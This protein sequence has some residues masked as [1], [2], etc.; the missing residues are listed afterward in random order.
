[1]AGRRDREEIS[2][3]NHPPFK[4]REENRT[5][6]RNW[7]LAVLTAV[8]T[9]HL[10][11]RHVVSLLLQPI[12]DDLRLTD[13]QLGVITGIAFGLF[14]ATLGVPIARWADRGNRVTII[15]LAIA[16]WSVTV[17][18][19]LFV[20]DFIQLLM[21][22]VAAS[23]GEAGCKPPTYSL[24]GDYFAE[25]RQR[26]RA[27]TIYVA[28]SSLSELISFG[29][30]GWLNECFGWRL[31]LFLVGLPGLL[32][33]LL[34]KLT[35]DEPRLSQAP[36]SSHEPKVGTRDAL[37][38]FWQQR[39]FR[40]ITFAMILVYVMGTGLYPWY[41]AFMIRSHGIDIATLGVWLGGIFGLA[42]LAGI[43]LGGY[44]AYQWLSDETAH[45]RFS[46]I[47]MALVVPCFFIFLTA[48]GKYM[49]LAMLVPLTILLNMFLGPTYALMQR[50]VPERLRATALAF[51]MLLANLIGFG[52]GPLLVGTLSDLLSPSLGLESLRYAMLGMSLIAG[53]ASYHFWQAGNT[54]IGDLAAVAGVQPCIE[55]TPN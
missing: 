31:S 2:Q 43:F 28:G 15:S 23:I 3:S 13:T 41:A 35:V 29:S 1:M 40:Q 50:L 49:A 33:A 34:V 32:L 25:P 11:D 53:W 9:F 55:S 14:Y 52:V 17:M 26:T 36:V 10:M 21:V 8:Y 5:P 44:V 7:A 48:T 42:G 46:A 30:A 16:I 37:R 39:S 47:S 12:K 19:C 51:V 38:G 18:S 27:L 24:V 54:I 6:N 20:R 45:M 4:S 22:R